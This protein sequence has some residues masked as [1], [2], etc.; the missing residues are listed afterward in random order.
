MSRIVFR[1]AMTVVCIA[2]VTIFPSMTDLIPKIMTV[3]AFQKTIIPGIA[4]LFA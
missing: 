2:V 3:S 1:I 4:K